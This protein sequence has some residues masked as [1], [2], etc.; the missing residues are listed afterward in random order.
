MRLDVL[1][2]H[3]KPLHI[4]V[5]NKCHELNIICNKGILNFYNLFVLVM[6][7]VSGLCS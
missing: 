1:C 2:G 3:T 5:L 4:F 7:V 6:N